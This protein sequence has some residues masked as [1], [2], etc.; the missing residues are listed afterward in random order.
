NMRV[1]NNPENE[2][3]VKFSLRAGEGSEPTVQ[4]GHQD[5]IRIPEQH[6]F[7]PDPPVGN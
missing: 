6:D 5:Y 3:F 4:R 7:R 2:P 1:A